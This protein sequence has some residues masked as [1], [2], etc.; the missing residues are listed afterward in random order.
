M[1]RDFIELL[2]STEIGRR[3]YKKLKRYYE[4]IYIEAIK[5][6]EETGKKSAFGDYVMK[7]VPEE[8]LTEFI[9]YH[10]IREAEMPRTMDGLLEMAFN[11]V[12]V[13]GFT[14][15]AANEIVLHIDEA[16]RKRIIEE[17][18][19]IVKKRGHEIVILKVVKEVA[20]KTI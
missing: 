9:L 15:E 3:L 19:N 17:S 7:Q 10:R 8:D 4:R 1:D 5:T 12:Y 16:R 2:L 18:E 20:S 14:E 13:N 11:L 6:V